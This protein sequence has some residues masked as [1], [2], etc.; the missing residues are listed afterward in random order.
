MI[1]KHDLTLNVTSSVLEK[2]SIVL[3]FRGGPRDGQELR[4]NARDASSHRVDEAMMYWFAAANGEVGVQFNC[5]SPCAM[6][7]LAAEGYE[8]A[9]RKSGGPLHRFRYEV[10]DKKELSRE[11]CVLCQFRGEGSALRCG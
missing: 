6:E 10:I 8:N 4:S 3:C 5:L 11:L 9:R 1:N 2:K 7:L